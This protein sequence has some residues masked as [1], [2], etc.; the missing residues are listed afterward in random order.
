M[1]LTC[2]TCSLKDLAAFV[3][4]VDT[5][6]AK[7]LSDGDY[8]ALV[9]VIGILMR[10]KERQAA[11]D[12]MFEPL[13]QAIELL[14]IYN[15]ELPDEVYQHL[16]VG[17][18]CEISVTGEISVK[19]SSFRKLTAPNTTFT[20]MLFKLRFSAVRQIFL[21]RRKSAV[22]LRNIANGLRFDRDQCGSFAV[23]AVN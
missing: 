17:A 20:R 2:A 7:P 4:E 15:Q 14:K 5:E 23:S 19:F 22:V 9:N 8:D 6:L 13:K 16:Q 1:T 10:L 11:T 12:E 3:T 18:G 21:S